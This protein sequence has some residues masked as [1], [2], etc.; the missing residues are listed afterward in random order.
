MALARAATYMMATS[1]ACALLLLMLGFSRRNRRYIPYIIG[2]L[3]IATIAYSLAVLDVVPGLDWILSPITA[4]TGKDRS[5]TN[6]AL[7]WQITREHIGFSPIIGTGYGGFWVTAQPGTQAYDFFVPRTYFYPGECHDGYLEVMNDLGLVGLLLLFGYLAN[8][9][10]SA[11]KLL[12]TNYTQAALYLAI[13]FQQLLSGLTESNWLWLDAEM[14]I[15]TLATMCLA[16]HRLE[17]RPIVGSQLPLA[18]RAQI[19]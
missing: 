7:I 2:A 5:F 4:L 12:K 15:L 11:L 8:Y 16:R 14:I 17:R 1:L 10:R 6:R 19:S 13:L 9:L 18:R 3:V